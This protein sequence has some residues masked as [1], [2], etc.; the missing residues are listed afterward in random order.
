M[1]TLAS[2][3]RVQHILYALLLFNVVHCV[4][5]FEQPVF[6]FSRSIVTR[7]QL[8]FCIPVTV[9]GNG[10]SWVSCSESLTDK[11]YGR[12][13]ALNATAW[14]GLFALSNTNLS[15]NSLTEANPWSRL[16]VHV[17]NAVQCSV[18]L[19]LLD[20]SYIECVSMRVPLILSNGGTCQRLLPLLHW[21]WTHIVT[22][23]SN[24]I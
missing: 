20:G 8:R 1:I 12:L 18:K 4:F 24:S 11:N 7:I 23:H 6:H 16:C 9:T 10:I 17:T 21:E 19:L 13:S 14:A 22:L 5:M 2:N 3:H 15:I